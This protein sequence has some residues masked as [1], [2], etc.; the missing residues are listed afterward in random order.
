M[1]ARANHTAVTAGKHSLVEF[2]FCENTDETKD[3]EP[4]ALAGYRLLRLGDGGWRSNLCAAVATV[5]SRRC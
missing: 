2:E 3:C 1:A 5:C 4:C